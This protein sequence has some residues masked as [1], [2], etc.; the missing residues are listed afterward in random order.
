[1]EED[2][3]CGCSPELCV[4]DSRYFA[5][6][7]TAKERADETNMVITMMMLMMMLMMIVMILM[8]MM[9]MIK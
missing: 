7:V 1:M 9:M 2:E 8:L 5:R 6:W 4:S 3:C